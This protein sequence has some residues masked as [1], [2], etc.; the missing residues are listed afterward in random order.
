[1]IATSSLH[2]PECPAG[3]TASFVWKCLPY[4]IL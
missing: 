1:M 3:V 4:F 2:S